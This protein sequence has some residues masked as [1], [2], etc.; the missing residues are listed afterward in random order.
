MAETCG[1]LLE[2]DDWEEAI[3]RAARCLRLNETRRAR[4]SNLSHLE[5][6]RTTFETCDLADQQVDA[7][8]A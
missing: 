4:R 2:E 3:R 5:H 7:H 8:D 1:T 6:I